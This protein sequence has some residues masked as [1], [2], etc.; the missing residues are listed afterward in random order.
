MKT[1]TI[2]TAPL[3][4][5][6]TPTTLDLIHNMAETHDFFE[7]VVTMKPSIHCTSGMIRVVLRS[8]LFDPQDA[9]DAWVAALSG[10]QVRVN[11]DGSNRH[12][13]K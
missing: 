10:L 13:D 8:K 11:Y 5:T 2:R 3:G 6:D 7:V 1:A 9:A 4:S 12:L